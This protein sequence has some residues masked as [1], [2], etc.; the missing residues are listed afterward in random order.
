[1]KSRLAPVIGNSPKLLRIYFPKEDF[2][3]IIS[4]TNNDKEW[5]VKVETIGVW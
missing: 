3:F 1:M 2:H 4:H 5:A